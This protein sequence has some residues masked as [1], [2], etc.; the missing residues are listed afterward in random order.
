SES[1]GTIGP[2]GN[3]PFRARPSRATGATAGQTCAFYR[4]SATSRRGPMAGHTGSD[5]DDGQTARR[6]RKRQ[7]NQSLPEAPH[8]GGG[9]CLTSPGHRRLP[10]NRRFIEGRNPLP[11]NTSGD[12]RAPLTPPLTPDSE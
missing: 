2:P 4:I 3:G 1:N 5:W 11:A 9:P 12:R 10:V 6:G 7:K 8:G